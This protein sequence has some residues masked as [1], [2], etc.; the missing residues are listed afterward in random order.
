MLIYH[1]DVE[2]GDSTLIMDT[3]SRRSLLVDAGDRGYGRNIL[4]PELKKLGLNQINYFL[5]THYDADHI[6]G[7]HELIDEGILF[8]EAV[9]DRGGVTSRTETTAKGNKTEYGTYIEY[10]SS[11]RT[12]LRP[13]CDKTIDLGPDISVMVV[14][15]AGEFLKE[16]KP[17]CVLDSISIPKNK[18]NDLS[19]ALVISIGNFSYFIGGDL[20]GGGN[21]TKKMEPLVARAVGDIDVLKVNHHG[22]ETSS[23]E[24]FLRFLLPEVAVISIGN[25]GRNLKYRLPRQ[26][27]LDRLSDLESDPTVFLTNSGEGGRLSDSY[28]E[29]R[30]IIV[31]SDGESYHVNGIIYSAN[32]N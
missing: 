27:I 25:G 23:N 19:I 10:A 14:A 7:F 8:T 4:V 12:T 29:D 2:T 24:D 21:G 32:D 30:H 26:S 22:S 17:S 28:V 16:T 13:G 20:T 31:F 11:L 1:F 18:D 5:A 15:G 6:G 3:V 9:F